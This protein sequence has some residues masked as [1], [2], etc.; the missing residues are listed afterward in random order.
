MVSPGSHGGGGMVVLPVVVSPVVVVVE[1]AL[2]PESVP[3]AL[4]VEVAGPVVGEVVDVVMPSEFEPAVLLLSES[5]PVPLEVVGVVVL[6]DVGVPVVSAVPAL[7]LA[8]SLP[9]PPE[10][11]HAAATARHNPI[12]FRLETMVR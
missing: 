7:A 6:P 10:S 1:V 3:V 4:V 2:T 9:R 5:L 8:L 12:R 11:P